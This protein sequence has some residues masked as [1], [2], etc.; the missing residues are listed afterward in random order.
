M[1]FEEGK[2]LIESLD[3]VEALWVFQDGELEYSENFENL[4][5]K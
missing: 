1:S 5:K 4:I 3:D 2:A